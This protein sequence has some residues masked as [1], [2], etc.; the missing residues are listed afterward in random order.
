MVLDLVFDGFLRISMVYITQTSKYL[1]FLEFLRILVKNGLI[2]EK[3]GPK[4]KI[5]ISQKHIFDYNLRK[6]HGRKLK[7]CQVT[8]ENDWKK[9]LQLLFWPHF[10]K[11]GL[12]MLQNRWEWTI[13]QHSSSGS[14]FCLTEPKNENLVD[15]WYGLFHLYIDLGHHSWQNSCK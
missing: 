3:V 1:I 12:C 4:L 6:K 8:G 5:A 9:M 13:G 10:E 2:L 7:F 15:W 11:N 14:C